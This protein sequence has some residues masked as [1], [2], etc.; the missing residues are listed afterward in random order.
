[1]STGTVVFIV[2]IALVVIGAIAA[3]ALSAARRRQLQQRFGPEYDR[4][5][6]EHDSRLK[7]EAELARRQRRVSKLDIQP[8]EPAAQ[9]RYAQEWA[10]IQEQFVNAPT[11]AVGQA[12]SL[13]VAV[14]RDRG[15]PAGDQDQLLADL[16]VDHAAFVDH[17]RSAA[18]LSERAVSGQP[19][20][21]DLRRAMIHYRALF[22]DLLG[23]PATGDPSGDP[24]GADDR[25]IA[26]DQSADVAREAAG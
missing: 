5:V 2:V 4:L 12:Q 13:V 25:P 9:A 21:E 22:Q 3:V 15:Y 24:A 20:T 6:Q 10:T 11:G 8:L 26:D 1:M 19:S 18:D 23:E 16:S 14:M 17:Y 7:A